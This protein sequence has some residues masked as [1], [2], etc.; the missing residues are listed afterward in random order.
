MAGLKPFRK[1]P[2]D[3]VEWTRWM[4]D[5]DDAITTAA[6]ETSSVDGT[7]IS[8]NLLSNYSIAHN[9]S[10]LNGNAASFNYVTAQSW[11]IDL[12]NATDNVTLTLSG[13]PSLGAYG[14]MNI[15]VRQDGTANRTITWAGGTFL[16]P[17]GAAPVLTATANALD[18]FHFQTVDQGATWE[19]SAIQD[20]S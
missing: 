1:I 15:R 8:G 9:I 14:E 7:E 5:Q 18:I 11:Y 13:G 4:R 6:A 16:W 20:L 10:T 3:V 17:A 12:E 19:G 2:E